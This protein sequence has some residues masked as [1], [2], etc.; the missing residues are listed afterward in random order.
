VTLVFRA[1]ELTDLEHKPLA[2]PSAEPLSGDIATR[3]WVPFVSD[4]ERIL[5]G[6]W[7]CEPGRS[8][9]EFLDR[10]EF[11]HVL[12]GSM[13]A[14]RDGAQS[15]LLTAGSSARDAAQGVHSVPLALSGHLLSC[16]CSSLLRLSKPSK[17]SC[18]SCRWTPSQSC[19]R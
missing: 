10:G 4:D 3:S 17:A 5:C 6:T 8:R 12:S 15:V 14:E 2:Q 16:S 19:L 13:T 9:W 18:G 1:A 11:I 7:G